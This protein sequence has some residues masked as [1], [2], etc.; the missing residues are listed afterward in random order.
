M[1]FQNTIPETLAKSSPVTKST[2]RR[3]ATETDVASPSTSP[4]EYSRDASSDL[5]T[6]LVDKPETPS[7]GFSTPL[8]YYTPLNSLTYFLNRSSQFHTA[9]SPDILALVTS[10]TTTPTRA[11]KG[12]KHWNTTLS[13]TDASTWP[14][15]PTTVNIFRAY[16]TALPQADAGDVI[17]LRAFAVKSLN[18]H[19]M[20]VSADESA[21]CV[22]RYGK[23]VWGAKRGVWGKLKAREEMRGPGVERRE[24]EWKEVERLRG[25][26][27][28][29]I[30]DEVE[31]REEA[32]VHT[33]SHDK[34]TEH[35]S[36]DGGEESAS[37]VR[38][39]RSKGKQAVRGNVEPK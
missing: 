14:S 38:T 26:W 10:G 33:R 17:L 31:E 19:S 12:P 23:P 15:T 9:S 39:R 4:A 1:A 36:S 6:T 13:I 32:K 37:Q 22:W 5:E 35:G 7:I 34:G 21:W 24:G 27:V 18:R 3:N 28:R 30:R 25:W 2:P 16:Q 20:L 11:T 8:A 29:R